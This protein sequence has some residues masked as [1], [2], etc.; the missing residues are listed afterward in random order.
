MPRLFWKLQGKERNES[1]SA[2]Q[3]RGFLGKSPGRRSRRFM[4]QRQGGIR[5]NDSNCLLG[6][7]L[8]SSQRVFWKLRVWDQEGKVSAWTKPSTWTMGILQDADWQAHWIGGPDTNVP[9]LLLRHEFTVK[10]G[11]RRALIN[12]CGLASINSR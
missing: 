8:K 12:I 6:P 3:I 11:L 9:S 10:P 5:R 1:Q 2:Y 7:A 4:G